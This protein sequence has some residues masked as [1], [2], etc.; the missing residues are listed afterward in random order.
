[1]STLGW[2]DD[3]SNNSPV[4]ILILDHGYNTHTP[5]TSTPRTC[6]GC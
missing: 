2:I 1:M 5:P 3:I 4:T 6:A